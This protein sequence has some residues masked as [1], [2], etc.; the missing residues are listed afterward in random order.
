MLYIARQDAVCTVRTV[1][2]W[3]L[4]F[5]NSLFYFNRKKSI[6]LQFF[7]FVSNFFI[8]SLVSNFCRMRRIG[9]FNG[10]FTGPDDRR[11]VVHCRVPTASSAQ[12][13][14]L[15]RQKLEYYESTL[16]DLKDALDHGR[17]TAS[18]HRR[19]CKRLEDLRRAAQS[20]VGALLSSLI[21][22]T[23]VPCPGSNLPPLFMFYLTL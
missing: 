12:K 18:Y 7:Q 17:I 22:V 2:L 19:R 23:F 3:H 15:L 13:Q 20:R 16:A 4:R 9:H 6:S 5:Y 14:R 8:N 11:V 10:T 1:I 21:T